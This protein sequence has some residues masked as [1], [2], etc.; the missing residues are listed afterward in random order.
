MSLIFHKKTA[1]SIVEY[2]A[3]III[4]IGALVV[5]GPYV[6][7]AFG[8]H[9]KKSGDSFG[10][11]RRFNK[12]TIECDYFQTGPSTG[13]WYDATCFQAQVQGCSAANITCEDEVRVTCQTSFCT[14]R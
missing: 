14:N 8:G 12:N 5:M 2:M 3:L 1:A 9:W 11:G 13:I 10:L 6:I 7:K 4:I